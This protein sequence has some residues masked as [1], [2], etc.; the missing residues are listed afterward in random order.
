LKDLKCQVFSLLPIVSD[1]Q[2]NVDRSVIGSLLRGL[3]DFRVCGPLLRRGL[4][5]A[6]K[7]FPKHGFFVEM[8]RQALGNEDIVQPVAPWKLARE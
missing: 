6:R 1:A 7:P 4:P 8:G 5:A 3:R 2:V